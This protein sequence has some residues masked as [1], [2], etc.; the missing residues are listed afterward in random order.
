MLSLG[1]SLDISYINSFRSLGTAVERVW[2]G[3][4]S[5]DNWSDAAN[6]IGNTAPVNNNS[7][8]FAGSTRLN[9][10]NNISA[11]KVNNITFSADAGAFSIGGNAFTQLNNSRIVNYS[12]NSQTISNNIVLKTGTAGGTVNCDTAAIILNGIISGANA[13]IKTGLNVLTLNGINT[14]TGGT[15]VN[16][17]TIKIGN[18]RALGIGQLTLAPD[19]VLDLNRYPLRNYMIGDDSAN[20]VSDITSKI[21]NSGSDMLS[22]RPNCLSPTTGTVFAQIDDTPIGGIGG[23]ISLRLGHMGAAVTLA[24]ANNKIRGKVIL[25]G[26]STTTVVNMNAGSFGTEDLECGNNDSTQILIYTGSAPSDIGSRDIGL[27][28]NNGLP[29]G[30]LTIKNNGI[31]ML[32]F[33]GVYSDNDTVAKLLTLG[34][35]NTGNNN[36]KGVIRNAATNGIISVEKIETGKWILF[37]ANTYTGVTAI[38]NGTLVLDG[39]TN[40]L[41]ISASIILGN[42]DTAGKLVLGGITAANQTLSSLTTTG[43]GGSVVGG[44]SANST[45]TLSLAN[46]TSSIFTGIFGGNDT[47]ENNLTLSKAQS[48]TGILT[49]TGDNTFSGGVILSPGSGKIIAAHNNALG[50]GAITINGGTQLELVNG[51][52]ISNNA[53]ITSQGTNKDI[54]LQ[55]G[56]TS[57]TYTG[58]IVNGED[59]GINFNLAAGTG[60]TL[61]VSGNISSGIG[62]MTAGLEKTGSGKVILTGTNT[63][64]GI[65]TITSGILQLGDGTNNK[66]STIDGAS[67]V[68]NSNLTYNR[69]GTISYSG[70]ISGAGSVTKSGVGTQI[71]AGAN[72]YTGLTRVSEGTLKLQGANMWKTS[73]TYTIDSAAVLNLDGGVNFGTGTNATTTI[74]GTGTLLLTNG[75]YTKGIATGANIAMALSVGGLIDIQGNASLYNGGW[76]MWNW[77][78]NNASMNLEGNLN[79]AE[80]SVT[81][82]ALTG[83]GTITKTL[84]GA[85]NLTVGVGNGNGTFSGTISNASGSIALIKTGSGT[86]T[87]SGANTYTGATSILSGNLVVVKATAD[88]ASIATATFEPTQLSVVFSP[89]L[90]AAT[91]VRFFPGETTQLYSTTPALVGADGFSGTYNSANS[92]LTLNQINLILQSKAYTADG[93]I[94]LEDSGNAIPDYW[95][96]NNRSIAQVTLKSQLDT[97]GPGAFYNCTSLANITIHNN[98]SNIGDR[99]FEGS[100]LTNITIPNKVTIIKTRAF[101][102]CINLTNVTLSNNVT[103][104]ESSA[105][106]YCAKLTNVVLGSGVRSIGNNAFSNCT[107]LPSITIPDG[108]LSI[109]SLAFSHCSNLSSATIPSSVISIGNNAFS[110]CTRLP[111]ITIPDGVTSIDSYAFYN[112]SNLTNINILPS[113]KLSSIKNDAFASC[114]KLT[115]FTIPDGV[116]VIEYRAFTSCNSLTNMTI[117]ENV[118]TIEDHAF[119]YCTGLTNLTLGSKVTNIGLYAFR[120]CTALRSINCLAPIAPTLGNGVFQEVNATQIHVPIGATGYDTTFGGLTVV[121]SL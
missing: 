57:A 52:T 46:G 39:G 13:L 100:G 80:T 20:I 40:R 89:P 91:T 111:T 45:L 96:A 118:A 112:C 93:T 3:L 101:S 107:L 72:T 49:I 115:N 75:T 24:N 94:L 33:R 64:T 55:D 22:N 99:A 78:N 106:Q 105:F 73:R 11:L 114:I 85:V 68:N 79:T 48:T 116:T 5:S 90:L 69:F 32:T 117:P 83:N 61:T 25:T 17:G 36:I 119:Y 102:N 12:N 8:I 88:L 63:Y 47:N 56:A 108:A 10:A 34:G 81:I 76:G 70:I 77:T 30:G 38:K 95:A 98:I 82:D 28:C 9:P 103:N 50:T 7:L 31:G 59:G 37:G 109:G 121:Y 41:P 60:G 65:T 113:S 19:A 23:S 29:G 15:V 54:V 26:I 18:A 104:I 2:Y 43:L 44:N 6:W 66:D 21:I 97:I 1:L 35:T 58:N 27:T 87:L 86:Q 42:V 62:I 14:Y 92:T 71:L 84:A 120:G 51:I 110:N 53:I 4:G 16:A 67:I 74:N